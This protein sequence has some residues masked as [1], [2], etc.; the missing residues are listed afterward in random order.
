MQKIGKFHAA[1]MM[2]AERQPDV[3]KPYSFGVFNQEKRNPY[4]GQFFEG[5]LNS[6]IEEVSNWSGYE[7]IAAKLRKMLVRE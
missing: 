1:S 6:L 2:L 5:S 4:F 3:M 7:T